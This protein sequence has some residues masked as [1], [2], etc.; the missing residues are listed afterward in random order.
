[1]AEHI[2]KEVESWRDQG[3]PDRGEG[4]RYRNVPTPKMWIFHAPSGY[5]GIVWHQRD[6]AKTPRVEAVWICAFGYEPHIGDP[7][8]NVYDWA[9]ELDAADPS[10]LMP[11]RADYQR[12][13]SERLKLLAASSLKAAQDLRAEADAK[14]G[15]SARGDVLG[16]DCGLTD[17]GLGIYQLRVPYDVG[18]MQVRQVIA[19]SFPEAVDDLDRTTEPEIDY[20]KRRWRTWTFIAERN[21]VRSPS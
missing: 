6:A 1:M 2:R 5:R 11:Q 14:P 10:R 12:Y 4:L 16:I 15:T 18:E 9:A 17:H 7:G 3:F 8:P 19:M 21:Q 20:A 13:E